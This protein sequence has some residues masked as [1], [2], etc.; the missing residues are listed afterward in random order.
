MFLR[1]LGAVAT[2]WQLGYRPSLDGVRGLGLAMVLVG[3]AG[4]PW[5]DSTAHQFGVE[6]FF[7]LSGF[8]ITSLLIAEFQTAGGIDIRRFFVRRVRRLLPALVLFLGVV[9]VV[10]LFAKAFG[11]RTA[12]LR[13]AAA[14]LTYSSDILPVHQLK[15]GPFEHLWSLAVE[16]H[17]YLVWPLVVVAIIAAVPT[18]WVLRAG[19]LASLIGCLCCVL[20]R[21]RLVSVGAGAQW[22][23]MYTATDTRALAPLAGCALAFVMRMFGPTSRRWVNEGVGLA[24]VGTLLWLSG[25]PDAA[26]PPD[27]WLIGLPAATAAGIGLCY[28]CAAQ[29]TRTTLVLSL[30]WLR[31]LGSISYSGYLWHYPIFLLLGRMAHLSWSRALLGVGVTLAIAQF[32]TSVVEARFRRKAPRIPEAGSTSTPGLNVVPL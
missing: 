15:L 17:F 21:A 32:S 11:G 10:G 29:P 9:T 14:G 1:T 30:G 6:V 22:T 20:W 12:T 8:L 7:V 26:W 25:R 13:G 2:D 3:H 24:S 19:L 28:A 16:E 27:L 5:N 4:W 18:K 23:R 31:W